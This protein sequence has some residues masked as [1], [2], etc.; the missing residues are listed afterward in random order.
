MDF[1]HSFPNIRSIVGIDFDDAPF[2]TIES[3]AKSEL[4]NQ[5][6]TVMWSHEYHFA[7]L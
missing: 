7:L 5:P 3:N 4:S 2:T 6:M 1:T